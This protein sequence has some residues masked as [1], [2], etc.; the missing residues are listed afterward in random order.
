MNK[1]FHLRTN[2][3]HCQTPRLPFSS[4]CRP[5]PC[6]LRTGAPRDEYDL[7]ARTPVYAL[8][9]SRRSSPV[10][11]GTAFLERIGAQRALTGRASQLRLAELDRDLLNRWMALEPEGFELGWWDGPYPD[12]E[13]ENVVEL[14]SQI[15]GIIAEDVD[16]AIPLSGDCNG[17]SYIR[18]LGYVCVTKFGGAALLTIADQKMSVSSG[19]ERR[20]G[21]VPRTAR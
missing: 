16:A 3:R 11:S 21:A 8:K 20:A 6:L 9:R 12:E 14:N 4:P 10:P 2:H 15:R 1:V 7:P 13:I 17:A 18:C 5:D 19:K